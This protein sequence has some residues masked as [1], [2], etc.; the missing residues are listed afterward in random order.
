MEGR[1]RAG[2]G[3]TCGC[4]SASAVGG[5]ENQQVTE[6][7]VEICDVDD[8]PSVD[9]ENDTSTLQDGEA[10]GKFVPSPLVP[11]RDQIEK[12][13]V[14]LLSHFSII[15]IVGFYQCQIFNCLYSISI[16]CICNLLGRGRDEIVCIHVIIA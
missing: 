7:P 6:K 4:A 5:D 3:Q 11:L 16:Y 14:C 1:E 8:D 10:I 13:K 2:A 9:E 15:F 12:D